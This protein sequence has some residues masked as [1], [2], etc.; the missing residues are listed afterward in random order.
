PGSSGLILSNH[1]SNQES[2]VLVFLP[3]NFYLQYTKKL[4]SFALLQHYVSDDRQQHGDK[5]LISRELRKDLTL[6]CS[7]IR[8]CTKPNLQ[9]SKAK[10]YLQNKDEQHKEDLRQNC[11]TISPSSP[12]N[13]SHN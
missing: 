3:Y 8:L 12:Y 4:Q 9:H 6:Q 11:P 2:K 5:E 10:T 1:L 13:N 7:K